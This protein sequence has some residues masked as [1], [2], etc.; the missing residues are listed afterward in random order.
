MFICHTFQ[1]GRYISIAHTGIFIMF[2]L[3]HMFAE[4]IPSSAGNLIDEQQNTS[5]GFLN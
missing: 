5:E 1:H 4:M 3:G 2:A